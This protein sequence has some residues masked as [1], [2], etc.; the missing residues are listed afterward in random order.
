M[1]RDARAAAR[2]EWRAA[3]RRRA[4]A[5]LAAAAWV[6]GLLACL[7]LAMGWLRCRLT[8]R[9]ARHPTVGLLTLTLTLTPTLTL[10]LTL[11]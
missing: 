1:R 4:A 8:P 9:C 6:L 3:A 7:A 5:T 2:R 10:T 11:T